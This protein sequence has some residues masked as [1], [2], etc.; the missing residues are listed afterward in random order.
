[1]I[2]YKTNKQAFI[3]AVLVV[4]LCL[5]SLS[6]ATFALFTSNTNDGKIGVVTTAGNIKVDIVDAN[7]GQS[8]LVGDVLD[9]QDVTGN[10]EILFEPGAAFHTQGFK[11][12]NDGDI[13]INFRLAVSDDEEMDMEKFSEAFEVWISKSKSY[14][15]E[16]KKL[17]DFIGRVEADSLSDDTYYLFVKMKESAGNDFQ[18]TPYEGIGVTVYAVQGNIIFEEK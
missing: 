8:S 15:E 10:T 7:D 16:S 2:R 12:K 18:G 9:F 1:M 11:V 17:T 4:L 14:D 6:G 3:I 13:P 5:V